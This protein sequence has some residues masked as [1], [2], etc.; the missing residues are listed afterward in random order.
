MSFEAVSQ[1]LHELQ[2]S[3]KQLKELIDRL[4]TIKFQPG[5]IPLK[6]DEDNVLEELKTEIRQI[7]REQSEDFETLEVDV[8]FLGRRSRSSDIQAQKDTLDESVKRG[9]TELKAYV[10]LQVWIYRQILTCSQA[11]DRIQKRGSGSQR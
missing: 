6:D 4:A 2:E 11:S 7:I 5:S 10:E 9:V 3:N 8:S 1:R